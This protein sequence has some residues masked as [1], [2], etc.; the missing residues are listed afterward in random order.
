TLLG[1]AGEPVGELTFPSALNGYPVTGIDDGAFESCEE[2]I[3]VI[4]PEGITYI[5]D[6]AFWGCA[7]LNSVTIPESVISIGDDAFQEC[8]NLALIVTQGSFAEQYAKENEIPYEYI[9][10]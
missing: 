1:Y 3:S 7:G 2:L 10:E 9:V 8:E 6:E 4:L 5:G